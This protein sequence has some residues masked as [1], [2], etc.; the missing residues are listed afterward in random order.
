MH[1]FVTDCGS[2]AMRAP[3]PYALTLRTA[4]PFHFVRL[5]H[6]LVA[7][8]LALALTACEQTA[9]V[10]Q[11]PVT[12]RIAGAT[13]MRLVLRDLS[14]EYS[15]QHPNVLFDLR[16]GGS[17]LGETLAASQ[18]TDLGATTL[19]PPQALAD[20]AT[21]AT[22]ALVRI[23]IGLDGVAVIVHGSNRVNALSLVQLRD[24]YGGQLLDWQSLGSDN[25]DIL[26]V[27]REDGSG[28]RALFESR[29]MGDE[30]VSLTAVVMPTSADVLDY[31]AH[32]PQAIGYLSRADVAG[33][34]PPGSESTEAAAVVPL[35]PNVR[36]VAVEGELPTIDAISAQR[37]ALLQP[38]YLVS[39]EE[40]QGRV[41]QF[42]DFVLGP[43]GQ[44]IVAR[45]HAPVRGLQT[46]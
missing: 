37:Y 1:N 20:G 36:V 14:A 38:L 11:P 21:P 18:Q 10:T 5:W 4:A 39:H 24:I 8:L 42:V 3:L 34:L 32:N 13:S 43:V 35:L 27:S 2:Y 9:L 40:P 29:V 17:L 7:V 12:I 45:Y 44:G 15:R 6:W 16:G 26:L 19:F 25:G 31:V 30:P 23:P 28:S 33:L 22:D 41:R 46:P